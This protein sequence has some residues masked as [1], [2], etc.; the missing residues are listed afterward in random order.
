[1]R[2][3]IN[4]CYKKELEWSTLVTSQDLLVWELTGFETAAESQLQLVFN[5]TRR[6]GQNFPSLLSVHHHSLS[7]S[8]FHFL[9]TFKLTYY[10]NNP[11]PWQVINWLL[12]S[13][14]TLWTISHHFILNFRNL[15]Y[16]QSSFRDRE[17]ERTKWKWKARSGEWYCS[18]EDPGLEGYEDIFSGL[19]WSPILS[20]FELQY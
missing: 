2:S 5:R 15:F 17:G 13:L 3:S 16:L 1:M 4:K 14:A 6:M 9:L 20:F 7:L 8:L 19:A 12:K 18:Q 10:G 11:L